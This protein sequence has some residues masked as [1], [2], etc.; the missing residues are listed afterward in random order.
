MKRKERCGTV[1]NTQHPY[2]HRDDKCLMHYIFTSVVTCVHTVRMLCINIT[3][4]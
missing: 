3:S 1:L 4:I 2:K